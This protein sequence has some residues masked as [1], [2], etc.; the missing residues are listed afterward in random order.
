MTDLLFTLAVA[1]LVR[2][3]ALAAAVAL[4][5]A[6]FRIRSS[7]TRHTAWVAVLVTML[8]LPVLTRVVP[9]IRVSVP[10]RALPFEL[11]PP[12]RQIDT[13]LP[14]LPAS[15][16][17]RK[18]GAEAPPVAMPRLQLP[19]A[20]TSPAA[21]VRWDVAGLAIYL[22]GLAFFLVRYV[23]GLTQLARIRRHSRPVTLANGQ[24][25][26]QSTHIATPATIG[27]LKP[28]VI[29]PTA[30]R[31]WPPEML[32]AVLAH[33]RAHCSRRDPLIAMMA[34]L[35]TTVFWFHPLSWW[36][37][38]KLA[39][40]AEHACDEAALTQVPRREY[41]E[42]LLDIATTAR[43]HNGRLVWQG[44][45]VDGDGRLGQRIDLVLSGKS[46]PKASRARLAVVAASCATA[47]VVAVACQQAAKVEPLRE[48]PEVAAKMKTN[49]DRNREYWAARD[50]TLEQAAVFEKSLERNPEDEASRG[51]LLNFYAWTG[52]NKQSWKDNVLARRR[53]ALWLVE[54]HPDSRLVLSVAVTKETDPIGYAEL[55]KR[56]LALTGP[57]N[58]DPTVL[59]NAAW[60]FALPPGH[61]F[62]PAGPQELQQAEALLLRARKSAIGTEA[63]SANRL[64]NLYVSALAPRS[65]TV[66]PTL[67]AW[68]KHSLD[69]S[70]DAGVL[71]W[72]GLSL[73]SRPQFRELGRSY[74]E[75]AS[76]LDGPAAQKARRWLG[77][78]DL[79]SGA[80]QS[81]WPEIVAKS[82]GL[83]KLRQLA[84]MADTSY[85]QAE[86]SDWRAGQPAGG[87]DASSDAAKDKRLAVEG[88]ANAK[89]Y[90]RD[91]IEL[92]SSLTSAG[93]SEA[94]F[95]AHHTYGLVLLH[96]GD[97]KGAV[98]QMQEA[99]KLPAPQSDEP[100]GLW[101]S[102]LE[103][104]LVF[105]LLKNGERQT[106]VDYFERASQGR[107]EARRKVMLAS[108]AA[109]REGRMPEHYQLL[110]AGGSL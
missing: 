59:S 77:Q 1:T 62:Q 61:P 87:T 72:A 11:A 6:V 105:Y 53:H 65:G 100:I 70:S 63:P 79:F 76:R 7:G 39:T 47:I 60:F 97:R 16:T 92:A 102:G 58:A 38:R 109:I 4:V 49:L 68:G 48:D 86:Y 69:E 13:P 57:A 88:F 67:A 19:D 42:T 29:V 103:Y 26:W 14:E 31:E 91:L 41:A 84:Y 21:P 9:P 54:H 52:K 83:L 106:I 66:D 17:S 44:V 85:Q 98:T 104:K 55:R 56:W 81:A 99:A 95:S 80:P 27:L 50:M 22:T 51:K 94:E 108:A 30:W 36:L 96:E 101:A 71:L 33:E 23:I 2:A 34:R 37:E 8:L 24:V 74:V 75:R 28:R 78:I 3:T 12:V 45:G 25:I 5:L 18:G 10:D 90:A 15:I 73:I 32:T 64:V 35:N 82:T 40:L 93:V 20:P 107:D 110:L 43:R 46:W 89:Q